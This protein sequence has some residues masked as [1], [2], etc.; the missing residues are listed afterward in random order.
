M[1]VA[2]FVMAARRLEAVM[3]ASGYRVHGHDLAD[4]ITSEAGMALVLDHHVIRP[5]YLRG[6][7]EQAI[8][9]VGLAGAE[10]GKLT[11]ADEASIIARYLE[12]RETYGRAPMPDAG[13]RARPV[14]ALVEQGRLSQS[15]GSFQP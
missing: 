7:L 12:V 4:W 1:G 8:A 15:R 10:P 6:T 3:R 11:D 13:Q 14:L 5:S 2:Q 9:D